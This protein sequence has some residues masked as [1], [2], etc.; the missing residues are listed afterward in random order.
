MTEKTKTKENEA[1]GTEGVQRCVMPAYGDK[2]IFNRY[3]QRSSK[4]EKRGKDYYGNL[5]YWAERLC[6]M[7]GIFLGTRTLKDG[8]RDYDSYEGCTF[9]PIRHYQA[10]LISPGPNENPLYVPLTAIKAYMMILSRPVMAARS[11]RD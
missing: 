4:E 1:E 6:D 11:D 2:V 3:Y 9:S 8:W 7:E 10:A 5:K